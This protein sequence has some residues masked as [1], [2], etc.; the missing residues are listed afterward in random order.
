MTVNINQ[1]MESFISGNSP[2]TLADIYSDYINIAIW[3]RDLSI[4]LQHA[5]NSILESNPVLQIV[6]T[7]SVSE[8]V[9]ML[10]KELGGTHEASIVAEDICTLVDMYCCLF[11]LERV[12]LRVTKLD[13]AMC[14]KF[15]IDRVPARLVTTYQGNGSEWLPNYS[16]DRTKLGIASVGIPDSES[17]LFQQPMDIQNLTPGDVAL[18]KGESWIGN[19]GRGIVHRSPSVPDGNHRLVMTLDFSPDE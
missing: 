16:V 17:G 13:R 8:C 18:L 10:Y 14:P 1:E 2:V 12:A 15:H 9:D 5:V 3:Q 7:V 11:E 4:D 19:E 6:C